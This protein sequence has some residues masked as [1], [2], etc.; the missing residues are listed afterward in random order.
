MRSLMLAAALAAAILAPAPAFSASVTID[1]LPPRNG[2]IVD[3]GSFAAAGGALPIG[4]TGYGRG[5]SPDVYWTG[6]PE[7][8]RSYVVL[9]ED[10]APAGPSVFWTLFNVPEFVTNVPADEAWDTDPPGLK[11]GAN[12]AGEAGYLP[13][14]P[15]AG[16]PHHYHLQV[17]A[18]DTVLPLADGAAHADLVKAMTGH[19]IASG[20][21]VAAFT[22]P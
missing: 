9:M 2:G 6:G 21:T 11:V 14:K 15:A 4:A 13:P 19:V 7:G 22:A 20:E 8:V 18:L 3:V 12:S 16:K 10:D 1:Q 17:F 5:V